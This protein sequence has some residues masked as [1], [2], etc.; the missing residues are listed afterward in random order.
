VAQGLERPFKAQHH[1]PLD[2]LDFPLKI[3]YPARA[4]TEGMDEQRRHFQIHENDLKG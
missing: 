3:S 4:T 1:A 2:S